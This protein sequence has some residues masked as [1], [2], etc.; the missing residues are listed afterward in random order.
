MI[1]FINNMLLMFDIM[2]IRT[3]KNIMK[4]NIIASKASLLTN[5]FRLIHISV[6]YHFKLFLLINKKYIIYIIIR[7]FFY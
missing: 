2:H 4:T 5:S 6:S 7:M 3:L 1:I